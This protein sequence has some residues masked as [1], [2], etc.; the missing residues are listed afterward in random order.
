MDAKLTK[1][2]GDD[3]LCYRIRTERNKK[4]A[5]R[6]DF[7]G[8]LI[9]LYKE[10]SALRLRKQRLGWEPLKPPVQKGWKRVFVLRQDVARSKQAGFYTG[11]LAKINTTQWSHRKD[12]KVKKRVHGRKK[13][14]VKEQFLLKP[15]SWQFQKLDLTEAEKLQ[16]HEE[17]TYEKGRGNFIKRYV[18]N[19]PWRFVL[20]VQPNIIDKIRKKDPELEARLHEIAS[21]LE[22]NAFRRIQSRLLYGHARWRYRSGV[23][24]RNEV[25]CLK[26]KSLTK[27]LDEIKQ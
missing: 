7:H 8:R 19:E 2:Y 13:Y 26:N 14:V 17:W 11:I 5:Q 4:R 3:I 23:E 20:K 27:I 15:D 10:E 22:K 9:Q 6:E 1:L 12:F 18:F 24:R 16:F 21:Y 25:T